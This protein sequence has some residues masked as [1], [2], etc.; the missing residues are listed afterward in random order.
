M[1]FICHS[2]IQVFYDALEKYSYYIEQNFGF[3]F[4]REFR[5]LKKQGYL[6]L[7]DLLSLDP[8]LQSVDQLECSLGGV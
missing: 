7:A 6:C 1:C 4:Q 8:E 5:G 2:T 3:C